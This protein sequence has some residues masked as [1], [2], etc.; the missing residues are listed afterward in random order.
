MGKTPEMLKVESAFGCN[1][2]NLLICF[3]TGLNEF[4][5]FQGFRND[6][7][8]GHPRIQGRIG[9]LKNQLSLFSIF[10]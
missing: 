4:H 2:T 7:P 3:L 5:H 9:I 8:D 1:L 6:V 10:L